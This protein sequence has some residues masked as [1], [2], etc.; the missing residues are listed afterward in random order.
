MN[1]IPTL[2]LLLTLLVLLL[3]VLIT[4]RRQRAK[5]YKEWLQSPQGKAHTKEM[6]KPVTNSDLNRTLMLM[7]ISGAITPQQRN[8]IYIKTSPYTKG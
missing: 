6:N 7:Q 1:T 2:I 4:S 8:E 3:W 5:A